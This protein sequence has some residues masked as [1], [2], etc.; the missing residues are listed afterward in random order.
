MVS[1]LGG[2]VP[3]VLLF[4]VFLFAQVA[5]VNDHV[6]GTGVCFLFG[7]GTLSNPSKESNRN[8]TCLN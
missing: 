7:L 3:F 4:L 6:V 8:V 2:S 1:S 5:M